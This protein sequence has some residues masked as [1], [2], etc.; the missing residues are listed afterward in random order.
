VEIGHDQSKEARQ[1][2]T[3][4]PPDRVGGAAPFRRKRSVIGDAVI[5]LPADR[6]SPLL[7]G[8]DPMTLDAA[9][10]TMGQEGLPKST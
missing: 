7:K 1:T 6:L 5:G 4:T 10:R 8:A 3:L 9:Y 2:V